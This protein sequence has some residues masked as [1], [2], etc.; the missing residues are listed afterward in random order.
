MK[1]VIRPHT[2]H[3]VWSKGT[4]ANILS[5]LADRYLTKITSGTLCF[6]QHVCCH[7]FASF[8]KSWSALLMLLSIY[9]LQSLSSML[10]IA[11]YCLAIKNRLLKTCWQSP[12]GSINLWIY[13]F[14]NLL[15]FSGYRLIL[16]AQ[17]FLLCPL[18]SRRNFIWEGFC[19]I[20]FEVTKFYQNCLKVPERL[21][22]EWSAFQQPP[23]LRRGYWHKVS[24][25]LR[26]GETTQH[27]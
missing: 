1:V 3:T 5:Y 11:A 20:V 6:S 16:F 25:C 22:L 8:L 14:Y 9:F 15:K 19:L 7:H 27:L 23:T 24:R 18:L 21:L 2:C 10:A 4:K 17:Y 12:S 26:E 13:L